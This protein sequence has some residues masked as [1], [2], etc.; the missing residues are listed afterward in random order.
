ML[1]SA[2]PFP[3][4]G[5]RSKAKF[6]VMSPELEELALEV[7]DG[8]SLSTALAIPGGKRSISETHG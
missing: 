4:S 2:T 1:L 5:F 6:I 3:E 8:Q 7:T